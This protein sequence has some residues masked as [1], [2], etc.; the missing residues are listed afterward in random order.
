MRSSRFYQSETSEI[1]KLDSNSVFITDFSTFKNNF[2]EKL[3]SPEKLLWTVDSDDLGLFG[4]VK[5]LFYSVEDLV[6]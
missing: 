1:P 3:D 5:T 4:H 2:A 6:S